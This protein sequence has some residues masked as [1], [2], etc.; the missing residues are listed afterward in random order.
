MNKTDTIG[1]IG[2]SGQLGGAI[3]RALL[4]NGGI[5]PEQLVIANRSGTIGGFSEW[6]G[7]RVTTD[8]SAVVR[9][10]STI[11][12]SVPP[13][14][15]PD[16]A[17]DAP[18]RLVI[19]VMAGIPVE[20]LMQ[21]TG[22]ARVVRAMSSPAA[23]V[24][25]AYS[26]WFAAPAV[27]GEDRRLVVSLFEA[28]GITDELPDE[29]QIDLF[30]AMTG[31][32]PGFVAYFAACMVDYAVRRGVASETADRAVRQLFL[33]SGSIIAN[34][35]ASPADHVREMIDYAGTTAAGLTAMK[36]SPL[37]DAIETGLDAAC[38]RARSIG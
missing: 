23:D 15:A 29:D 7:L 12:L 36:N 38:A 28:C 25:L 19:S 21:I 6:R 27:T 35:D 1:I 22:A 8:N 4:R 17:I 5:A 24:G 2:G 26:P 31:P 14:S 20:R 16:I 10:C 11:I 33:A 18:D 32:V 34:A 3:A 9:D 37:A 13:A 30:T